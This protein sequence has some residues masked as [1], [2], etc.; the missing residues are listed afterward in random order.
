[1]KRSIY[2]LCHGSVVTL[3]FVLGELAYLY[4]GLEPN[5]QKGNTLAAM[6]SSMVILALFLLLYVS[7]VYLP[8]IALLKNSTRLWDHTTGPVHR[9]SFVLLR[10]TVLAY[11]K[12]EDHDPQDYLK[13]VRIAWVTSVVVTAVFIG[14]VLW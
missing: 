6:Q 4:G 11:L 9:K 14:Y 1:M 12:E 2:N 3:C 5:F 8:M 7:G 13:W 10:E